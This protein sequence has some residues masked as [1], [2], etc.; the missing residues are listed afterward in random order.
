MKNKEKKVVVTGAAG[1][2][3]YQLLFRIANGELFGKDQP[4]ALYLL[5]I[6]EMQ[7]ALEGVRM[8]LDD[9]AFP[10]LHSITL[11]SDPYKVFEGASHA[12]LVGSKPR[13]PGMERSE[14]LSE[15]GKIFVTQGKA[16]NQVAE[17]DVKVL[18][19]GNPCNTNCLIAMENAPSLNKNNFHA[20]TRLDQNRAVFQL[21]KK[22]GVPNHAVSHMTIWGN[23]SSSQVPDF[24]H[25]K[26]NGKNALAVIPDLNWLQK[27]FI[28]LIQK[29]GASVLAARGKSSAGS[30]ANAALEAMIDISTPTPNGIWYSSGVF[31]DKN[32]YG[33]DN[34][35]V[36]SFPCKTNQDGTVEIISGLALDPFLVERLKL[37]E[38]ELIEERGI[39]CQMFCSK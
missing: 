37:S 39:I 21:A 28:P 27:E 35:L 2:I 24:Y 17:R 36:Y 12:F 29:R 16:L 3:A 33:I 25:A 19:V 15:N 6:P 20:M 8:E 14:L 13:T 9:C 7:G 38:N 18:V 32:P 10:C 11:G 31:S 23:H 5:E 34:Y 22:A 30:A 4:V 1:Q 26:I